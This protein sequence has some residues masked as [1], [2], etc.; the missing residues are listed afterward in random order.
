M[1]KRDDQHLLRSLRAGRSGACAE[2]I[3]A[4]YQTVYRFLVH[5]TR[6]V[7]QAEDL[8]QE[9]FAGAWERIATFEGRASLAT[10]LHRIAYTRF[11]D[12]ERAER[13]AAGMLERLS[14]PNIWLS[15]PLDTVIADDEAQHLYRAMCELDAPVRALL[16]LHYLQ[17][18]SYREMASVLDEPTGTVKWR[19]CEALKRLRALLSDE[20]PD[21]AYRKTSEPEPIS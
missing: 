4:H 15:D 20:V 6:D 13:R 9:T 7:H 21:H 5:L 14:R 12:A 10:W 2:L 16:V 18:L 17:G 8:T 19:T 11:I 3:R 1:R